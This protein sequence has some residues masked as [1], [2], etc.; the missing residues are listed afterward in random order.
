MSKNLSL[1]IKTA[2]QIVLVLSGL[3]AACLIIINVLSA[4]QLFGQPTNLTPAKIREQQL[5]QA[6]QL[7]QTK[8]LE[9]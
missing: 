2:Y 9:N 5:I 8:N 3:I 1:D 7:V 4:I 6:I